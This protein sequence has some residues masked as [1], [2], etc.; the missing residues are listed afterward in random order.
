MF[1]HDPARR[2]TMESLVDHPYFEGMY[3]PSSSARLFFP[4][5]MGLSSNWEAITKGELPVPD[6]GSPPYTVS[7]DEKFF[8]SF[9]AGGIYLGSDDPVPEFNYASPLLAAEGYD[10]DEFET[11]G[12]DS[13]ED[14]EGRD[15]N[16]DNDRFEVVGIVDP[17]RL[18]P[19]NSFEDVP[20]DDDLAPTLA[21]TVDFP[22]ESFA[23]APSAIP[24][25]PPPIFFG[26]VGVTTTVTVTV[27]GEDEEEDTSLED[28][29]KSHQVEN[30]VVIM[31]AVQPQVSSLSIV[32]FRSTNLRIQRPGF[33]SRFKSWLGNIASGISQLY[34]RVALR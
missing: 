16:I 13:D 33:F 11:Y 27:E 34:S 28:K 25:G 26:M 24:V 6:V 2:P 3:V 17:A 15:D 14:F 19:Q 5:L 20:L 31:A 22:T 23:S 10:D 12:N 9:G 29:Q 30:P 4:E 7:D 8:G 1:A 18:R 21:P 32:S